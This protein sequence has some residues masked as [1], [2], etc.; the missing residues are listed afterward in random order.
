[1]A[2]SPVE[3][4]IRVDKN[5]IDLGGSNYGFRYLISSAETHRRISAG[6]W[7]WHL[8]PEAASVTYC[9]FN[10][11]EG[12]V[13]DDAKLSLSTPVACPECGKRG[14]IVNGKWRDAR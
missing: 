8:V 12:L 4:S 10:I 7:M 14:S 9:K 3:F 11:P 6:I 2:T 5:C 1:M 13:S